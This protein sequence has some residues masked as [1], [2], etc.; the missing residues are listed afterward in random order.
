MARMFKSI[1]LPTDGSQYSL[2][3]GEYA[4]DIAQHYGSRLV[5]VYVVPISVAYVLSLRGKMEQT[6]ELLKQG[7]RSVEAVKRMC[8]E[9]HV[10]AEGRVVQG[11]PAMEILRLAE[12]ENADLVVIGAR[13]KGR[14]AA[15]TVGSVSDTVLAEARCPVMVVVG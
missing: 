10:L 6:E 9:V 7:E 11:D 3:A 4:I 15:F 12:A 14:A 13:R 1:L 2:N 5:I 8:D